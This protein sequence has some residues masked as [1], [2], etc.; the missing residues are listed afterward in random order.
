MKV[1]SALFSG[2]RSGLCKFGNNGAMLLALNILLAW[3]PL[4]SSLY[5]PYSFPLLLENIDMKL[6]SEWI[7]ELPSNALS[8]SIFSL[9]YRWLSLKRVSFTSQSWL[10]FVST[11]AAFSADV[12][13]INAEIN[14]NFSV[15]KD[16]TNSN[17]TN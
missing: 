7:N 2:S 16:L 6:L 13:F 10:T 11:I 17:L 15:K 8:W 9:V 12:G 3:E 5:I 4:E 14:K 1:S